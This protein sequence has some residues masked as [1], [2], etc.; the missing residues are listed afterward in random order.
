MEQILESEK[1]LEPEQIPK[2]KV[3][4]YCKSKDI[5][6]FRFQHLSCCKSC[7]YKIRKYR[8]FLKYPEQSK[9]FCAKCVDILKPCKV[10]KLIKSDFKVFK[11]SKYKIYDCQFCGDNQES[12]FIKFR[13][14]TCRNC[15]NQIRREKYETSSSELKEL[16]GKNS[17]KEKSKPINFP[18]EI[19]NLWK[20]FYE[21]S[22]ELS[23]EIQIKNEEI[24]DL[25]EQI[26]ILKAKII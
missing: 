12:N 9:K 10:C 6:D 11:V 16:F 22:Q 18:D 7:E 4:K 20:N 13:Y 24:L 8:Y 21:L 2:F 19:T 3:C 15:H 23:L 25:K 14:S 5:V 26:S 17:S 1:T